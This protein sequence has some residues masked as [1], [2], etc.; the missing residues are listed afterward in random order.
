MKHSLGTR[1]YH[2]TSPPK[3][4]ILAAGKD[5]FLREFSL[6]LRLIGLRVTT[7]KD[8][9]PHADRIRQV[10]LTFG[11]PHYLRDVHTLT[12]SIH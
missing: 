11:T 9:Q 12:K 10:K 1:R 3:G 2:A 6:K 7:P 8:F 5:L 4:D